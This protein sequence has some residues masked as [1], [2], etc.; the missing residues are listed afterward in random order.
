MITCIAFCTSG[1]NGLD[2]YFNAAATD[3]TKQTLETNLA[4]HAGL[5]GAEL[6]SMYGSTA[7]SMYILYV[8]KVTKT[9]LIVDS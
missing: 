8:E 5:P 6:Y 3:K 9:K 7:L 2:I 4:F 1:G